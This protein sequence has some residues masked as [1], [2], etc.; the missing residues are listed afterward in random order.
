[1]ASVGDAGK[2][3]VVGCV[4]RTRSFAWSTIVTPSVEN[5]ADIV[6]KCH[7]A[8]SSR[9]EHLWCVSLR[10]TH[11]TPVVGCVQRTRSFTLRTAITP[12]VKNL[13]DIAIKC[14]VALS[15]RREHLWCAPLRCTH[16][17]PGCLPLVSLLRGV[18]SFQPPLSAMAFG[19]FFHIGLF[20][21]FGRTGRVAL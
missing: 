1:M 21:N 11:P 20:Q 18:Q 4:Q 8:L 15:S 10:S 17:T 12:S 9:R 2:I 19:V 5:Q 14:H 16:P 13:A 6:I 7:V 3:V